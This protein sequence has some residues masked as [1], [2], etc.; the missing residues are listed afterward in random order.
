[1]RGSC[2]DDDYDSDEELEHQKK[3]IELTIKN[4]KS[5]PHR[6]RKKSGQKTKPD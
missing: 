1:M 2:D 6:S 3:I 5:A 4:R